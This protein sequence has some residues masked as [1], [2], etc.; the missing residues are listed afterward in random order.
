M[1]IS[2][3]GWT[4]DVRTF[5]RPTRID[6]VNAAPELP[7]PH[8]LLEVAIR[9]YA[10]GFPEER[11][12]RVELAAFP[13]MVSIYRG[14]T[15]GYFPPPQAEFAEEVARR[16]R[17]LPRSAVLAR[18][19]R[20]Y[21][22]FV[23]QHHAVLALREHFPVVAWDRWLDQL[24]GVDVLV[25]DERGLAAGVDL[26]TDTA[27]AREWHSI[28]GGRHAAP[29]IPVLQAYAA[30][31]E[32]RV[33]AFWLHDPERLVARVRAVLEQTIVRVL[34]ELEQGSEEVYR[35]TERRPK[36]SR[37]DFEAGVRGALA[38]FKE[39]LLGGARESER[40]SP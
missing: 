16:V 7:P 28:K 23:R 17:G 15:S 9:E 37:Q 22:S 40:R 25:V 33:G 18:A 13:D 5:D 29:P 39:R 11:D 8:R 10:L 1:T 27:S 14:L 32:Y 2:G 36:C 34:A 24:Q 4:G 31:R 6:R 35:R 26:S 30:P 19:S 38:F 3:V 12:S 21:P 20:A